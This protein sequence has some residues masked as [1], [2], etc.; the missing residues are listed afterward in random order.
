[1]IHSVIKK[2]INNNLF[3]VISKCADENAIDCYLIGGYVRDLIIGSKQPKDIDIMVVGDGIEIAKKVCKNLNPKTKIKIYKNF[4]TAAFKYKNF[5]IEFV[6]ARKESYKNSSRNPIVEIGTLNDDLNRRDFTINNIAIGLNSSNWGE[7]LDKFNGL[8]DIENKLIRTPLDPVKTFSDDPLRMLRGIRFSCQL[9]FNLHADLLNTISS[10]KNRINI[11]S[12]ERI[13]E[14]LNKILMTNKP[15][16][17]FKI[18]DE[19]GLLK[20]ILPELTALKGIDEI[21]GYKHKDNFYHTLEVLDNICLTTDNLWLRWSALLH[22]IGKA[23]TKEFINKIGW[24]FHGHELKG[25]KMVYKIF[26][27]LNL[28]LNNKL[29][30]VQK[31]IYMS[32]RPIILSNDNISDSAVRRLIYDANED[33]DDLLTLCEADIT[34]KNPNRFKK[35]LNNFKKV[36]KKIIEVEKRDHIRNFQPPISGEEIMKYFNLKPCREIGILKEF[37]KESILDGKI[38]ND[39]QSAKSLMIKKGLEI[40]LKKQ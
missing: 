19:T 18:L 10:E 30:Y 4:R 8:D 31:I 35:Y 27:R 33:V 23:P 14:E 7:I 11:I 13:S 40:G 36:R 16:I 5:D 20:I 32:S 9:K 39:Y 37:I 24:T 38:N 17:G 25:S 12:G 21:E 28:P 15:S 3:K 1:M 22:D 34:T 2:N 6:G 29:K 26:K